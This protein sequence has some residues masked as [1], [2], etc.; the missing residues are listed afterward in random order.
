MIHLNPCVWH[1]WLLILLNTS[2]GKVDSLSPRIGTG[3]IP[4]FGSS[5]LPLLHLSSKND[6]NADD[7]I[8]DIDAEEANDFI[9]K[10]SKIS[11]P[12]KTD[13]YGEDE[14][15]GLLEMHKQLQSAMM[16]PQEP[17]ELSAPKKI[18]SPEDLFAGG[19]HS[20]ILQTIDEIDEKK[21][22]VE[23]EASQAQP[24][25]SDS[26]RKKVSKLDIIAVASDV[27]GTII[28]FDQTIHPY[29]I[30][31]INDAQKKSELKY[32]FPA[33]GKTRWGA[34]NSLGPKLSTFTEGPG[35]Y[36]QVRATTSIL[37]FDRI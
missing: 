25:F 9:G 14:L 26:A 22:G 19:L 20:L 5:L 30:D 28:G 15:A 7:A 6:A 31:A 16:P 4:A 35:V 24:W 3:K 10:A 37:F 32:V 36:C 33:T 21:K 12:T 23:E 17:A 13:L 18:E 29:T 2:G 8:N 1:C 11:Q 34:R 27:D